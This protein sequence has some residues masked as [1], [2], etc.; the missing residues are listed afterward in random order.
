MYTTNNEGLLNNYAVEPPV[1]YAEFPSQWQ[2][3]QYALRGAFAF[4]FTVLTI[5]MAVS[6][7]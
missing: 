5:F 1:Y 2:Q 7:S 3:Q 4:L 6:V